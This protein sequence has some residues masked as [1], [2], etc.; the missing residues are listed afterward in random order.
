[1]K[2]LFVNFLIVSHVVFSSIPLMAVPNYPF[3][4]HNTYVD[5]VIKPTISQSVMDQKVK[6]L[7]NQWK[8]K[9]LAVRPDAPDQTYISYNQ[10]GT[11]KPTNAVCVSEGQG[12]GMIIAAFMAGHDPDAQEVFDSLFR[13]YQAFPSGNTAGLMGWQQLL[14]DNKIVYNTVDGGFNS[15]TDGDLDIAFALLLADQQWGSG[16]DVD[17][18]SHAN[19]MI[20]G[21]LSGDVNATIPILKLG[22]WVENK[23]KKY[24]KAT[25]PSDFMLNHMRNFA[26]SSNDMSWN[27][28]IDKTYAIINELHQN[29]SPDTGLLPD[30]TENV[31]GLYVPA[32]ASFL[33]RVLDGSYSWNA[34]RTPW[35]IATDYILSG[36]ERA[37]DQLT[38]LNSWIREATNENPANIKSGYKLDGEALVTYGNLAFSTPFAVSAMIDEDNQEWLDDL[39]TYTSGIATNKANYFDN[40][41]RLLCLIM[42]SG[43]WW[44]PLNLP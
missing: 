34:C 9:Y 39:W 31:K 8:Q 13:Y 11:S 10:D 44:T 41:I 35:R 14:V 24:G 27:A 32:R 36:D 20:T 21:I 15:A 22:D 19:E 17:Y 1:M 6:T 29:Y 18:L 37:W 26:S 2:N 23:D 30:F 28:L 38:K 12:Y 43:N 4:T 40:T 25:R 7:Y 5:G 3:P 42:V 33:E 16:G